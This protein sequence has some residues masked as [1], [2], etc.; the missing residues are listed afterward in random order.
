MTKTTISEKIEAGKEN[1]GKTGEK[2]PQKSRSKGKTPK[3]IMSRHIRDE[4]DV[5]TDEEFR[6]LATGA[7]LS[8]EKDTAHEPLEITSDKDRPK[9]EDKDPKIVTPWDVIT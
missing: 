6:E 5:I 2:I 9:D 7:D 3:Q 8:Q 1:S 4:K